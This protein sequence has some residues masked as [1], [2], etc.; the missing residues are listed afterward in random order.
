MEGRR[1]GGMEGWMEGRKDGWKEGRAYAGTQSESYGL[2]GS[3]AICTRNNMM[4]W[5][6]KED[7][8][9]KMEE[10]RKM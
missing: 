10:G 3:V 1:D 7:E 6:W 4:P 8:G 9:G 5:K 2:K